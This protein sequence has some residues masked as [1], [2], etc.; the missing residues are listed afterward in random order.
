VA[1]H[2]F[3]ADKQFCRNENENGRRNTIPEMEF[4]RVIYD[5]PGCL[6][7]RASR[8]HFRALQLDSSFLS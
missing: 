3:V 5:L 4:G 1:S 8:F 7:P 6:S 2:G